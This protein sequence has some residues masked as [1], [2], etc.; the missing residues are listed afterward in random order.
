MDDAVKLV[1]D[2]SASMETMKKDHAAVVA[3]LKEANAASST[4]A[5][6]AITKADELAQKISGLSTSIIEMEQKLADGVQ[7]GKTAPETLGR[8]VIKSEGFKQFAS[9]QTNKL[10]V[11]ANTVTGQDGGSPPSNSSVLVQP[12][13][14]NGIVG[15]AFRTLRIRDVI[16]TGSTTSNAVEYTRELSFTN[17]AAETAEGASKPEATLTFELVNAPVRTI[18]HF[19]KVSKQVLEDSA[20]LESYID[21]RL[22][23]GVE[24]RYDAQIITGNGTGQNISGLTKSGNYTAFSPTTGESA[25]DSINRAIYA[26]YAADY[27]PTAIILNPADWGAIERTKNGSTDQR[28][29]VG[30]PTG[31]LGPVLWGLPVIVTNNMTSGKLL[32][33]AFDISHQI[34]DRSGTVVEMFEQDDV[35]VQ[36]NLL[37][38]RAEARGCLATYRPAS[39][40]YGSTTA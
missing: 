40:F 26:A 1:A 36:K 11:Q 29:T 15:G 34:F 10:R 5:K 24:L 25:L 31:V 21:N 30:N 3:A 9:G 16:P 20:A 22:R 17:A 39:V 27:P 2:I 13:R 14:L 33:G 38:V 8:M 37:T 32:V 23:Y 12:Q 18:A 4:E 6:A 7:A 35:N 28:Y 19:I